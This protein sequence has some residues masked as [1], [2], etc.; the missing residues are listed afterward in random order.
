M[1]NLWADTF[2]LRLGYSQTTVRPDLRELT[3]SSYIDPITGDLVR[4]NPGVVPSDV[5]NIDLR[6]EWFFGNGDNLTLTLFQKDIT[7]PIEFFEIAASDTTIAR[8]ILNADSSEVKGIEIEGLKELAFLGGVFDTLFVQGNVTLQDSELI[9]GDPNDPN[10]TGTSDVSCFVTETL[11]SKINVVKNNC[12]L[13]GASDYVVNVMLGFDSRDSKHTAS[14][15]YNVFGE[16]VFAFGRFGPDAIEQ[17]FQSLDFTYFWYP[18]DRIIFK[19]KA[20]NILGSTTRI[21]RSEPGRRVT[22]F[23]EDPGTTFALALSWQF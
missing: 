12:R 22:V 9:P 1:G 2:Q 3:G 21:Q 17:P 4:G 11:G 23:E 8:E 16:R 13:S 20:Q 19:A 18:T 5:N 15:I 14:L 6:A 10:N 7:N